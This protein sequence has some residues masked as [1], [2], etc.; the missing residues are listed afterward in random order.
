[1]TRSAGG[2]WAFDFDGTL[3][4]L[5]PVPSDA[6]LDVACERLLD[7]LATDPHQKVAVIS[8]RTLDDLMT[9][10]RVDNVILAGGS[11]LEWWLPGDG[12]IGPHWR[13]AKRREAEKQRLQPTLRKLGNVPGVVVEDKTWS[14]AVHFR[15]VALEDRVGVTREI[16]NLRICYGATLYYGPEVAEIQFL[17]EVS[18]EFALKTFLALS[19]AE[20]AGQTIVYAGDDQNDALAMQ[21]V[22]DRG[23]V[24]YIVG[25][26]I[27][28]AGAEVV[29]DPTAL[30]RAIRGRL[31]VVG[32]T[33][34]H[35]TG[36]VVDE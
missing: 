33:S 7:D 23:G 9:R 22:L 19:G 27:S 3:S 17:P 20:A 4:H 8:S 14:A 13:A 34:T 6:T 21:W 24:A 35:R 11:G 1:M 15:N 2:I 5:V 36:G 32:G 28:L 10:I 16:E 12:R 25:D 26:G 30:A 18:K 31:R 29:P